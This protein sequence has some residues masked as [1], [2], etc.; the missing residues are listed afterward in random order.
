LQKGL[1]KDKIDQ[2]V[3]LYMSR[4]LHHGI[5]TQDNIKHYLKCPLQ[6]LIPRRREYTEFLIGGGQIGNQCDQLAAQN[7]GDLF[8]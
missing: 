4:L 8:K 5:R 6:I 2:T 1:K 7:T 3:E